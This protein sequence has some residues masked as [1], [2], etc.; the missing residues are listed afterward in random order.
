MGFEPTTPT[1]ARLC[2]TPE[3]RPRFPGMI[4]QARRFATG[5]RFRNPLQRRGTLRVHFG[6]TLNAGALRREATW[7]RSSAASQP[8]RADQGQRHPALRGRRDRGLEGGPGHRR[9]LGAVVRPVQAARAGAGKSRHG[10]ARPGTPGQDRHRREPRDRPADAHPVDPGGIRVRPGPAGRRLRRCAADGQVKA[11]VDKLGSAAGPSPVEDALA[12]AA[13]K[14][15][16]GD[17]AGA[18]PRSTARFSSNPRA[19]RWLWPG[20][21]GVI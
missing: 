4:V 18:P 16:G 6:A 7:N 3:L 15:E 19:I 2:S 21:R 9:F 11:F 20:W 14:R 10:G 17:L 13:E 12:Q 1:L 5:D 8:R